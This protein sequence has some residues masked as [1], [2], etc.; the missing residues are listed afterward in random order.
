MINRKHKFLINASGGKGKDSLVAY[1]QELYPTMNISTVDLSKEAGVIFGWDGGK[2][3]KDR[4]F[5]SDITNL[6]YE[7]NDAPYKYVKYHTEN[8]DKWLYFKF[9]F[10]HCREIENIKRYKA[11]FGF[12]TILV[13]NPNV[14][15]ITSNSADADACRTDYEYD[16]IIENDGTLEDLKTKVKEFVDKLESER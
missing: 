14:E 11:D 6:A 8:F 10:V 9:L 12:K 4:K 2:T 3:E 15:D 5:L 1:V 16:Y 13:K 7:Y